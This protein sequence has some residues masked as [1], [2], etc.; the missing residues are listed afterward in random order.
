LVASEHVHA[1]GLRVSAEL[2]AAELRR[3]CAR[4][5]PGHKPAH[6]GR[7]AAELHLAVLVEA[8]GA[9]PVKPVVA[10]LVHGSASGR[11]VELFAV[12][13]GLPAAGLLHAVGDRPS[14]EH[15][16]AELRRGCA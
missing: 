5:R 2:L 9:Q 7:L 16:A 4:S 13:H 15:V 10:V 12:G 6:V 1:V 3:D 14:A 8:V 11:D